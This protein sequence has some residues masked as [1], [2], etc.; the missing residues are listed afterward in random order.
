ME[1]RIKRICP[2]CGKE[3]IEAP[4]L[5]RADNKTLICS[6]CGTKEALEAAGMKGEEIEKIIS[7]I[8]KVEE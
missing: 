8:K 6:T 2:R 1:K 7:T 4:A 5:S 3:F